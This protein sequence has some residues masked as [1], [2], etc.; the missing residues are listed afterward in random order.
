ML[1][2]F[3]SSTEGY[4]GKS[5]IHAIHKLGANL[6]IYVACSDSNPEQTVIRSVLHSVAK[7]PW[8]DF[9]SPSLAIVP[10]GAFEPAQFDDEEI[11]PGYD[12]LFLLEPGVKTFAG[13]PPP[14]LIDI[15][16]RHDWFEFVRTSLPILRDLSAW[17]AENGA[18]CCFAEGGILVAVGPKEALPE[19]KAL[20]FPDP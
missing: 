10:A 6:G 20:L 14:D 12:I 5:I 18:I 15:A 1:D 8:A 3:I 11:F 17:M 9:L 13:P 7:I 19:P 16:E 2:R 4:W